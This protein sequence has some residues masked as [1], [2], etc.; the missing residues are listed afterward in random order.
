MSV[1]SSTSA[2]QRGVDVVSTI[3]FAAVRKRWGDEWSIR[4]TH[5]ADGTA[6][7]YVFRSRGVADD[8][9]EEKTLKQ[10]RLYTD[11]DR[12]VFR[13]VHFHTEDVVYMLEEHELEAEA[14][15]D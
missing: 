6:Q 9:R 5:F 14:D 2:F 4:A 10:G 12:T 3:S 11:G 13:R 7:A 15:R 8:D 1:G